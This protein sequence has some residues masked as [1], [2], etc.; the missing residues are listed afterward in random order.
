[1]FLHIGRHQTS[2]INSACM[3]LFFLEAAALMSHLLPILASIWFL[4]AD[5]SQRTFSREL[6]IIQDNF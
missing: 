4:L 2:F 6:K 1:M 3:R 5:A